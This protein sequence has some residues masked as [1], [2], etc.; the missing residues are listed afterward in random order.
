M[1]TEITAFG[2]NFCFCY[3]PKWL[4]PK[5]LIHFLHSFFSGGFYG[6]LMRKWFY[7]ILA[8]SR[9]LMKVDFPMWFVL[10]L[11]FVFWG[12]HPWLME[13]LRLG[14]ES[15]L[16]LLAYTTATATPN[17]SQAC[18]LHCSSQQRWI[19]NPLSEARDWIEPASSWI[20]VRFDTTESQWEL[21]GY[22]FLPFDFPVNLVYKVLSCALR[23]SLFRLEVHC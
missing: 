5:T 3:V 7:S 11:V 17:P 21:C 4:C 2:S 8:Q 6:T 22:S 13:V 12:P 15:E 18:D 16:Q 10:F 9:C 20:L 19:L 14:V 23:S 1:G